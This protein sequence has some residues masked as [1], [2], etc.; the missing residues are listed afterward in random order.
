[1]TLFLGCASEIYIPRFGFSGLLAIRASG[2]G[3]ITTSVFGFCSI[4][5]G[6]V[7]FCF[8]MQG[9]CSRQLYYLDA[10]TLNIIKNPPFFKKNG[11]SGMLEIVNRD[12]FR[13]KKKACHISTSS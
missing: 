12:L 5:L 8:V 4:F 9:G 2:Q 11:Y 1:L 7:H 13:G 6:C 3:L 10:T